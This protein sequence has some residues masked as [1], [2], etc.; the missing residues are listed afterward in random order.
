[1][2]VSRAFT[3]YWKPEPWEANAFQPIIHAASNEFN[4][5]G[6]GAGDKLYIT[7]Y[8]AREV[9]LGARLDVATTATRAEAAAALKVPVDEVWSARDHVLAETGIVQRL[10][11]DRVIPRDVLRELRCVGRG[12]GEIGLRFD[13]DGA[14]NSRHFARCAS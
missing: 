11:P 13:P 7:H 1:M 10:D 9:F 3:T 12:G 2:N 6:V 8:E 4:R 5:R 14:A